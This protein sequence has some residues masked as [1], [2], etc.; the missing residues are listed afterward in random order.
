[1]VF[2]CDQATGFSRDVSHD[3]VR[4]FD[5]LV[6][7]FEQARKTINALT[8]NVQG[9]LIARLERV[10]NVSRESARTSQTT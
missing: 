2:H 5:A 4:Y 7:R 3:D 8:A 6:R 10:R 1:M 9:D